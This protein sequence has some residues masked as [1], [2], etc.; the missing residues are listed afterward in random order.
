MQC[1]VVEEWWDGHD[2]YVGPFKDTAEYEFYCKITN[3]TAFEDR[4]QYKVECSEVPSGCAWFYYES[5]WFKKSGNKGFFATKRAA[6]VHLLK[7]NK[8]SDLDDFHFEKCQPVSVHQSRYYEQWKK[9]QSE[10]VAK[11]DQGK[12][13]VTLVATC[14]AP[15]SVQSGLEPVAKK[16]KIDQDKCDI[17]LV[18]TCI[19]PISAQSGERHVGESPLDS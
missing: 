12:S 19:A 2:S 17:T 18:A 13:D 9:W 10:P 3:K 5:V 11:I 1:I 15:H 8:D 16:P 6:M 7:A 14:I 4:K